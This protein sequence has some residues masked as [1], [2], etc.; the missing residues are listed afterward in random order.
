MFRLLQSTILF[1]AIGYL[2]Q[3]AAIVIFARILGSEGQGILTV[4]RSTAQIIA[5]II[6]FGLPSSIVYFVGKDRHNFNPLLK[7]CLGWFGFSFFI[8]VIAFYIL[9]VEKIPKVNVIEQYIP[10][11]LVLV[12]LLTFY[13]LFQRLMLSLKHYLYYNIFAFG[14]GLAIFFGSLL[15]TYTSTD[16]NRLNIAIGCYLAGY[17][18]MFLYGLVL[19]IREGHNIGWGNAIKLK[20]I[21]QFRVGLR[22]YLSA[23]AAMFLFRADLFLVAYFL[24]FKEVGIYSIALLGAE[25][26]IKIPNWSAAIL[27]PMVASAEDGHVRRTLFLF[28]SSLIIAVILGILIILLITLFPTFISNV[29]GRDFAGVETCLLFLL[30]RVVMQSGVGILAANLAGK[31]Y[32]W[33]HPVGCSIPLVFLII[34]DFILIP[35]MGIIGA[36]IGS[37]LSFISAVIIFRIGFHKYNEIT[38]DIRLKTF[39]CVIR[40]YFHGRLLSWMS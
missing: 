18:V 33:Y 6:W 12:C 11:L 10:F 13:D 25:M 31:G 4:F 36:A 34:L 30:P 14:L 3:F 40:K 29:L 1:Q 37:S 22:G 27:T 2:M 35:R 19:T 7:N 16:S 21:E 8:L 39:W 20:F 24:S 5:A 17:A 26:I 23:L 28:Y 15:T 32:P 9:P 38:D